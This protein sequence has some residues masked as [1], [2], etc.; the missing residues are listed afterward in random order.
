MNARMLTAASAVVLALGAG[1]AR[2]TT[3]DQFTISE[4]GLPTETF[5]LPSSPTPGNFTLDDNFHLYNVPASPAPIASLTFYSAGS[6]GGLNDH[7]NY[8]LYGT[9]LYAGTEANPTFATGTYALG[10]KVGGGTATVTIGAVT[11]LPSTW[12]MLLGGLGGLGFL[13][14]RGSRKNTAALGLA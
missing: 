3:F 7:V 10:N 12:A 9:Q 1:S 11:P 5:T 6:G 13:V 2:A 8:T 14:Y 4:P